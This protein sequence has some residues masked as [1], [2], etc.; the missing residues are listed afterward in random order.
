MVTRY[1]PINPHFPHFLHGGDYNP[2]QW[3]SETWLEDMRLMKLANCKPMSINIFGW[4]RL[5]P[6]KGRFDFSWVDRVMDLLAV[7]HA[8]AVPVDP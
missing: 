4:S 6:E 8:Y 5:E 7:N 2:D 3:P 1:P